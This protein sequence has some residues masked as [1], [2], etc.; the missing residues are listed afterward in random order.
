MGAKWSR[1]FILVEKRIQQ[2]P[3]Q[4]LSCFE[5]AVKR[6]LDLGKDI[7]VDRV[8]TSGTGIDGRRGRVVTG[9]MRDEISVQQYS[10][11]NKVG[12]FVGWIEGTPEYARWQELGFRHYISGEMVEGMRAL[13]S[14]KEEVWDEFRKE[15]EDCVK[16][17][18]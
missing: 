1:N 12:G 16:K 14:A 17:V 18:G 11:P 8:D 5:K 6:A 15:C 9:E 10:K 13:L 2:T 7:M 4:L 3:E